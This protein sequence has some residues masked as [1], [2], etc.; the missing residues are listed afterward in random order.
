MHIAKPV[1]PEALWAALL[2][3]W[4]GAIIGAPGVHLPDVRPEELRALAPLRDFLGSVE[5][6]SVPRALRSVEGNLPLVVRLLGRF[7]DGHAED[8]AQIEALLRA[9]IGRAR[10]A[11]RTR[12]RG[13]RGL[14]VSTSYAR[15]RTRWIWP[16]VRTPPRRTS[17]LW[18][19]PWAAI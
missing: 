2:Q 14:W 8:A 12:S 16:S 11:S 18:S 4:P 10:G 1:E 7:R 3:W 13:W 5:G 15:S 19:P 9:G 6:L 17:C